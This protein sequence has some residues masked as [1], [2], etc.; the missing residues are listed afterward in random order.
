MRAVIERAE[1]TEPE[2]NAF[3]DRMFERAMEAAVLAEKRYRPGGQPRPLEGIP[4]A[5]KEEQQ[6]VGHPVTDG[7]LLREPHLAQET[8]VGLSRIQAA[9]GILHARTTTSE[10]CCMPLS[11]TRRW[12]ITRN[13]WNLETSAGGSSGGSG[14]ALASG[15]TMLATGSDIGGS[16]RAPASFAGVVSFKPPH[17]RI[18][19][20]PPAG[21]DTYFH[22]GP[23]ARTVTDCALLQNVMSGEDSRDLHSRLPRVEI[24]AQLAGI[25][26]LRVAFC[27][28]PGD[29]PVDPEVAA[30]TRAVARALESA[31]A[32][33]TEIDLDW[34]LDL[35]KQ[36]LWAHFGTGLAA[37]VLELA[38]RNPDVIT[39]YCL[40]FAR[41][42]TVVDEGTGRAAES[43]IRERLAAVF[44]RFDTLIVPTIG[45]TAFA[46]GEDYVDTPLVVN[47]VALEHFSDASLTPAFNVSSE[48]PVLAVPSGWAC[49]GVP[50]GVQVVARKYD[51]VTAFRVAAAI[52][53]ELHSGQK[54]PQLRDDL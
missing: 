3:A 30:N 40:E 46:A 23:M 11:H 36:A 54:F 15:A 38:R 27:P 21:L 49:N 14:A 47:G 17:G 9:G 53:Q 24:P 28:I 35:I 31:G 19:V 52:E 26:S 8:A 51:D 33:V 41:K 42:G 6:L 25:T 2:V 50:T 29:F 44:T 48:N 10:F 4:V 7:T 16:L 13:P 22:H 12:G 20:L 34:T 18:P 32:T 45:A 43:A 1:R 39:P 5:A 37:E